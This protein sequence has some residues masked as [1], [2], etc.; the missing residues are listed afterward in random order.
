MTSMK[1]IHV[2]DTHSYHGF[3]DISKDID[4]IIHSGDASNSRCPY[5]NEQELRNFIT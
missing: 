5:T 4:L 1:I 2:S 3:L